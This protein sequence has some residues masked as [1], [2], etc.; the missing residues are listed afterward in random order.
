[1]RSATAYSPTWKGRLRSALT[2]YRLIT[3]QTQN[4]RA[5]NLRRRNQGFLCRDLGSN[6]EESEILSP[7]TNSQQAKTR[8]K[9]SNKNQEIKGRLDWP[10]FIFICV[11]DRKSKLSSRY[12]GASSQ[13]RILFDHPPTPRRNREFQRQ[14][15]FIPE[16]RRSALHTSRGR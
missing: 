1:M 13:T 10:P 2:V 4:E 9:G 12:S 15:S 16:A 8:N 6:S 7:R 3:N 14:L 5:R 11:K